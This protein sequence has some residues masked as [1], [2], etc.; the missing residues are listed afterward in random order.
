MMKL[1]SGVELG[2]RTI[3]RAP[4]RLPKMVQIAITSSCNMTCKMCPREKIETSNTHLDAEVAKDIIRRIDGVPRIAL[5]GLGEPL[6]HPKLEE[7]IQYATGRGIYVQVTS[8]GTMLR[9]EE[10]MRKLFASGLDAIA[11]SL[12]GLTTKSE[13]GHDNDAVAWN[14]ARFISLRNSLG[15]KKPYVTIQTVM[16]SEIMA[17]IPE[18]VRWAEDIGAEQVSLSRTNAILIPELVRPSV[19]EEQVFF[20]TVL[21]KLREKHKIRIDCLQ[22]QI[23]PG[24]LGRLYRLV[25]PVARLKTWCLKWSYYTYIMD[26]GEV[27]PCSAFYPKEMA[28]GNIFENSLEE[29]WNGTRYDALRKSQAKWNPCIVCDNLRMKQRVS[30]GHGKK[31]P[32]VE[33]GVI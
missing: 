19:A 14:I 16:L 6:L 31:A 10:R 7:I 28:L 32:G 33:V 15:L 25:L 8:N 22:D 9:K 3:F 5:V 11:F 26:D 1:K 29:I 13:L 12:E 18:L 20:K 21:R 30:P 24:P 17:E 23:L 27:R 4:S 2:L